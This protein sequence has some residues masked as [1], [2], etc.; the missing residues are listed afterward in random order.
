MIQARTLAGSHNVILIT[1]DTLRYDVAQKAFEEGRLPILSRHIKEWEQRHSPGSFTY[2]AH[3]AFFAGFLPT[4]VD[5]PTHKRLFA[6][7]FNGSTTID[8]NTLVFDSEN[9]VSGFR[10]MGYQTLCI[11]G[12]GFFNRQTPLGCVIPDM[13]CHSYWQ[14]EFGVTERNSTQHQINK[15]IEHL[16]QNTAPFFLFLNVSAIHQPN[17]FYRDG[18]NRDDKQS[19]Q[20]AL[21]YVDQQLARLFDWLPKRGDNLVIICSDH[22]TTYGEDNYHGHRLAHPHVWNVPYA[23]FI[24]ESNL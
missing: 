13:F 20:K 22:G 21:E 10:S 16:T 19:H 24:I 23:E 2:A 3:Q 4:P 8:E 18:D 9:I 1:L 12:V 6:L 15:A 14:E 5:S 11:G 7:D 17:Y